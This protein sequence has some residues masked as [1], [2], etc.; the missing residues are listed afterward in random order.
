MN[1][2]KEGQLL[3]ERLEPARMDVLRHAMKQD[4]EL[5]NFLKTP[6]KDL[7]DNYKFLVRELD[8]YIENATLYELIALSLSKRAGNFTCYFSMSGSNPTGFVAYQI[9]NNEVTD[10]KM[11]SFVPTR[12]GGTTLLLDLNRLLPQLIKDYNRVSWSAMAENPANEAYR[13][14]I[15]IYGGSFKE[16]GGE[17]LL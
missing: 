1:K 2:K 3:V 10:I 11:F 4:K 5:S 7:P 14:A 6:A 8:E 9:M 13:R 16:E 12:G 17:I 15:E